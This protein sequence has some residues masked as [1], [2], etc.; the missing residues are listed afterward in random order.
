MRARSSALRQAGCARARTRGALA[1][2]RFRL[3]PPFPASPPARQAITGDFALVKGHIAD[4]RGN[5]VFKGTA[6]NF[7]PDAAR[8]GRVT[9]VEVE[10][11]VEAGA[12]R[13]EDVHL[14]GIFVHRVVL[15][16]GYESEPFAPA[17]ARTCLR[18]LA[19][20]LTAIRAVPHPSPRRAH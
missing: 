18:L 17:C 20:A 15:G 14:P 3:P 16:E 8:A 7:N 9:I 10:R 1:R 2:T 5:V 13:P 12:L 4:T 11:V 6:R 19:R